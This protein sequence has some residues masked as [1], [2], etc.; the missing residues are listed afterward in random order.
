M[1][2]MLDIA[3][4]RYT[5]KHYDAAQPLTDEELDDLLEILR[6]APSSINI[7][8]WH[9]YVVRSPEARA[10]LLPA[11]MDFNIKRVEDASAIVLIATESGLVD[12]VA[13]VTD[14]ERADGRFD[15]A[16]R[17]SGFDR[18]VEAVRKSS[19]QRYCSGEDKGFHWASD[20][21]HIAL[22]FLLF[23][24]AGMGV[25]A[26][27]LGG[28]KFELVDELFG[29]KALGRRTVIGCALGHRAKDD[30]NACR[31]K[32]RLPREAIVTVL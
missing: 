10:K 3:R 4:E 24:A 31:P 23:G 25:D 18:E 26:T 28:I 14:Q 12:R 7:Q 16:A 27:A 17:A 2:T 30:S 1:N 21:A 11:I 5:A 22:G 6:L 20:Q 32:S 13:T 15:E 19:V 8:P 9:F 29:L